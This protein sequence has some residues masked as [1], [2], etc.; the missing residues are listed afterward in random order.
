M[1][2]KVASATPAPSSKAGGWKVVEAPVSALDDVKNAVQGGLIRGA[3]GFSDQIKGGTANANPLRMIGQAA[4]T[5]DQIGDL[6]QLVRGKHPAARVVQPIPAPPPVKAGSVDPNYRA[7]TTVG[8]Y[9]GSIAEMAPAAVVPGSTAA[10]VANVVLPGIGAQGAEDLARGLGAGDKVAGYARAAG[11]ILGGLGASARISGVPQIADI[12][13]LKTAV[14]AANNASGGRLLNPATEASKRLAE[15]LRIDGATPEEITKITQAWKASGASDPTLMDVVAKLPSG[16][17]ATI[18]LLRGAA[19]KSGPAQGAVKTYRADIARNLQPRVINRT[20]ELTPD[21]RTVP[22]M[23]SELTDRVRT[24]G[25]APDFQYGQG[26]AAVS[27]ALNA[28]A[29]AAKA[30]V[31]SA[32]ADARSAAPEAAHLPKSELP[33]IAA[34]VRESV[35]DFAPDA[36][37]RVTSA[38]SDLDRMNAPT[39]RDL[40]DLRSKLSNLRMSADPVEGAAAGRASQA[41]DKHIDEVVDSGVV[42]GDP[43]V[44]GLWRKAIGLRREFGQ[45]FEGD[46]IIHQLTDQ[47]RH[48]AGRAN[49]VAPED[50]SNLILGRNGVAPSADA[51]RDLRRIIS[52][53]GEKSIPV[54]SLRQEATGR[55]LSKDAGTAKFGDEF[56]RFQTRNPEL[57]GALFNPETV[58]SIGSARQEIGGLTRDQA[59]VEAGQGVLGKPAPYEASL[60][61]DRMD[62]T[63][64]SAARTI[65]EYLGAAKPGAVGN[66]NAMGSQNTTR[67]LA[68]TFGPD[69]AAR[70][71]EALANEAHRMGT[72]NSVDPNVNSRSAL[73]LSDDAELGSIP[74]SKLGVVKAIMQKVLNGGTLTDAERAAIVEL[75]LGPAKPMPLPPPPMRIRVQIPPVFTG[76]QP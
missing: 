4:D 34:G 50:A 32:Y 53:L 18:G 25:Q 26:G 54:Q 27:D 61:P 38:L 76:E 20:A 17:T 65:E 1:P 62:Q 13:V 74:T 59:A 51:T 6:V 75:G 56:N 41:L 35:R 67:N 72:A 33:K 23:L 52:T 71:Q 7:K 14:R 58:A 2:W 44:V 28:R 48:G 69:E 60:Q 46:D 19:L 47:T 11:G 21:Q 16:G 8:R 15:K 57:S 9:A 24:A 43:D 64:A 45:Q 12:P 73:N 70:Y 55:L 31:N 49:A 39:I 66:I 37:P 22:Q 40:F 36:V 63:G 68:A 10:R 42:T 29:T 3:R 5:A 30:A